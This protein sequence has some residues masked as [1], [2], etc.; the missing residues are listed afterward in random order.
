[1]SQKEYDEDQEKSV[2]QINQELIESDEAQET[3]TELLAGYN[4]ELKVKNLIKEITKSQNV[5]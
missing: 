5:I 3:G 4:L 1:M 2:A